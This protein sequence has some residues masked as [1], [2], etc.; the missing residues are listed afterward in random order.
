LHAEESNSEDFKQAGDKDMTPKWTGNEQELGRGQAVKAVQLASF[1]G[2]HMPVVIAHACCCGGCVL[3]ELRQDV[4]AMHLD[5]LR[6]FHQAQVRELVG[7]PQT[8]ASEG[9]KAVLAALLQEWS[10]SVWA[11]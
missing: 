5:M 3:Q 6:Q 8:V 11:S 4:K 9:V 10:R 7:V 1:L 2:C